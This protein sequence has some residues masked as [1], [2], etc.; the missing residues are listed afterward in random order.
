MNPLK[1]YFF[2][3]KNTDGANCCNNFVKTKIATE[4][5]WEKP[6][7]I[8]CLPFDECPQGSKHMW[9]RFHTAEFVEFV[10]LIDVT[11]NLP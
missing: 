11:Q 6:L 2:R 4:F 5:S 7:I 3:S 9:Y 10:K 1:C 8:I